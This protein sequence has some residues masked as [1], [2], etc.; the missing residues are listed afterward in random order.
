[1]TRNQIN[2]LTNVISFTLRKRLS[3]PVTISTITGTRQADHMMSYGAISLP[4]TFSQ[5]LS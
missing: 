3:K 5:P 1:M 2:A 4:A